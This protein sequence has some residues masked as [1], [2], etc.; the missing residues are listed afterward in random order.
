MINTVF[1]SS[2]SA[3]FEWQNDEAYYSPKEYTVYLDGVLVLRASTN[4]FSLFG[5][6]PDREYTLSSD[7][8]SVAFRTRSESVAVSL[9]DFGAVG[10]GV[11]D[12]TEAIR[13][14]IN[15]LPRGGRLYIPSGTYLTAPISLKSHMT[16]ELAE[17]ATLLGIADR[18][19]Y[20][21][22]PG[23]VQNL[24]GGPE[25]HF[26]GWEGCADY[27]Y[28]SLVFAEYAEDITIVGRGKIDGNG[29]AGG[30][31]QDDMRRGP[32]KRP[33]LVFFNR[34]DGVR[35][36]GIHALNSP[37]WNI[38]PYFSSNVDLLDISV[39][40]P[41]N[42]PNTD[43]IDP[44]ACD[45]VDIIGC[46]LSVGDDCIAIKSGKID[47]AA[48]FKKPADRHTVRNCLMQ[49]G[50]G[51]LT[52][53]S[54][55]GG[56]VTNLTVNKCVF[57]RTD[58]GLRI[59]TRRGRGKYCV[60]DGVLF[61]NIRMIGVLTPIVINSFYFC[62]PE[63]HTE[64]AQTRRALPIDDRTPT[65][66]SFTFRN[67][68][69]TD[70]EVAACYC[71]GLPERPIASVTLENIDFSFSESAKP[72]MPA[73]CEGIAPMCR[74]GLVLKCVDKLTLRNVEVKGTVGDE[75]IADRVGEIVRG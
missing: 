43:A 61:E 5:L 31:W 42:S 44:E 69:C 60:I 6:V 68:S 39:T 63:G 18:S 51:A 35:L 40:A 27:M 52:L 75:L 12:D 2:T 22:I 62:D 25:V 41:S 33:R 17:D 56:G 49:F 72:E 64:Y 74:A 24:N 14:A 15:C 70:C 21:V 47:L 66:G 46:K 54:E 11:T 37:C 59:K 9:K 13:T 58:R 48:I 45:R 16:L 57:E 36:H 67:M 29:K 3:C 30:W 26:G 32:I 71:E 19:R 4:V 38:H 23:T 65:L 8:E 20:P 73:M 50:H 10:D 28:Q 53:G 1:V 55:I 7:G 34:C